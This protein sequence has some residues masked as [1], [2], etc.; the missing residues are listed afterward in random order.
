MGLAHLGRDIV[1]NP[2]RLGRKCYN[3][4]NRPLKIEFSNVLAVKALLE[5]KYELLN[6]DYFY[7][8]YLNRGLTREEREAEIAERKKRNSRNFPDS[9]NGAGDRRGGGGNG[10]KPK[11]RV[12]PSTTDGKPNVVNGAAIPTAA[13]TPPAGGNPDVASSTEETID[14]T[15]TGCPNRVLNQ[16]EARDVLGISNNTT[17]GNIPEGN[18]PNDIAILSTPVR[19]EGEGEPGRVRKLVN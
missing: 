2:V 12:N 17:A 11:T 10:V 6:L 1:G 8:I 15:R 14:N 9:A 7:R 4:Q 3:G 18:G 16:E 13:L 19:G 5:A